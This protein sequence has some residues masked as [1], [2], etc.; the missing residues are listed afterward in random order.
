MIALFQT[1]L[2]GSRMASDSASHER[3]QTVNSPDQ[4]VPPG[5]PHPIAFLPGVAPAA[6]LRTPKLLDA[7]DDDDGVAVLLEA[8]GKLWD[9]PIT[10][11]WTPR[12][13]AC[14]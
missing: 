3:S 2:H 10:P 9:S 13:A 4:P 5:E 14:I 11:T 6:P 12:N 1:N 8:A 7:M